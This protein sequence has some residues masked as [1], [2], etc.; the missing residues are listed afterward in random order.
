[1]CGEGDTALF[2]GNLIGIKN[3]PIWRVFDSKLLLIPIGR[4]GTRAVANT[5]IAAGII[6]QLLA[7]STSTLARALSLSK[8]LPLRSLHSKAIPHALLVFILNT[9][10]IIQAQAFTVPRLTTSAAAI[11]Q[12]LANRKPLPGISRT[13][14]TIAKPKTLAAYH[15]F[16]KR[17]N[18]GLRGGGALLS[19]YGRGNTQNK[20]GHDNH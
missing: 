18:R 7:L 20:H 8:L 3:A 19:P 16:R 9:N 2:F 4:V 5:L 6:T 13:V 15:W 1:M 10:A 17:F 11:H 14:A 12:P